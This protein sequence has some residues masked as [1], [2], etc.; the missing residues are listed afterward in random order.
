LR[1]DQRSIAEEQELGVGLSGQR[2]RGAG[3]D[4]RCADVAA[5]AA[6][7]EALR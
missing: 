3:N 7:G 5:V 4:D 2:N 1:V 6:I